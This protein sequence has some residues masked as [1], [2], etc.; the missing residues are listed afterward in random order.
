M[1][2]LGIL[3]ED[4]PHLPKERCPGY[5]LVAFH[6]LDMM[7]KLM[8]WKPMCN[9]SGPNQFLAQLPVSLRFFVKPPCLVGAFRQ[10]ELG[11]P[12]KVGLSLP[13]HESDA[14]TRVQYLLH[15]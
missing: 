5:I 14:R 11:D 2:P 15:F 8:F 3:L 1:F 10:C 12:D 13:A 4:V 7:G 9:I 6:R